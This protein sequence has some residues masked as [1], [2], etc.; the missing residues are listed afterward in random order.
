M[1]VEAEAKAEIVPGLEVAGNYTYVHSENTTP[2]VNN[3]SH[4]YT[5]PMISR[6]A[7]NFTITRDLYHH[8]RLSVL[9]EYEARR[10]ASCWQTTPAP[11]LAIPLAR[12]S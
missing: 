6:H 8:L 9:G 2:D 3:V 4:K 12:C 5:T 1:G 10:L 7:A 11:T